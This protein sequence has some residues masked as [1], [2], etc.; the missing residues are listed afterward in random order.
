[1]WIQTQSRHAAGI[2]CGQIHQPGLPAF[3]KCRRSFV[4]RV[5]VVAELF[6]KLRILTYRIQ[7]F[8][9]RSVALRD[10]IHFDRPYDIVR[11]VGVLS[12]QRLAAD[13]YELLF[14][15]DPAGSPQNMINLLLLHSACSRLRATAYRRRA[16]TG[17]FGWSAR[18]C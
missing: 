13:D 3:G 6:M 15:R 9:A 17:A 14:A 7:P 16:A 10:E 2:A 11:Q 1:M 18:P 5:G 4:D 8:G 12:V